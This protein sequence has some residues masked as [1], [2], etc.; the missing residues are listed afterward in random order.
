[1]RGFLSDP[2]DG[3]KIIDRLGMGMDGGN[4]GFSRISLRRGRVPRLAASS[5]TYVDVE[6]VLGYGSKTPW[7]RNLIKNV[8]FQGVDANWTR[9]P[10]STRQEPNSCTLSR[11]RA[12]DELHDRSKRIRVVLIHQIQSWETS[13]RGYS[14]FLRRID[15]KV[16]ATTVG[17]YSCLKRSLSRSPQS[18]F[19]EL[20]GIAAWVIPDDDP[21]NSNILHSGAA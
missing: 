4:S 12:D 3:V 5:P 15:C 2:S 10:R 17:Q 14:S 11:I 1:M 13:G 6:V 18:K 21:Y 9:R 20:T 19:L 16:Y 8:D 7:V